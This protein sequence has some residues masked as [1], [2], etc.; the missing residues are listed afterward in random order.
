MEKEV[1][2]TT[3]N[4][5]FQKN[6]VNQEQVH[7]L[8][9]NREIGWQDIIYD[10]INTEQ[11]DPWNVDIII[12]ADKY[13]ER[14]REIEEADFFVSSKVLYAASLLLRIKSEFL[15]N[16]HI[17]SIDEI[18]FG[19]KEK[20]VYVSERIEL[21][22][23]IPELI[24]RSPLPRFKKVTLQEL[25]NSL[26]KTIKTENRRI[27]REIVKKNSLRQSSMSLP[28]SKINLR[29]RIKEIYKKL[30]FHLGKNDN[31]QKISLSE[32][33]EG[34]KEEKIISF[35]PLLQLENQEKIWLEQEFHFDEIYIWL[36]ETYLKNNPE[37]FADLREEIE[38]ANR[39]MDMKEKRRMEK[40]EKNFGNPLGIK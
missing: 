8:L 25:I 15:L 26:N 30:F 38:R 33:V 19:K 1:E 39:E 24:M 6:S 21:D 31:M 14:V 13:L 23:E 16:R 22:E 36:R 18:L 11:L 27:E 37:P 40:I 17:T 2:P 4:K 35:L 7:D 12:L 28:K 9:F 20:I 34:K 10:L 32:F 5:D 3:S 29:S